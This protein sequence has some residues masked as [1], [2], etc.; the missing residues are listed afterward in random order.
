[1]KIETLKSEIVR[2]LKQIIRIQ[3]A[4]LLLLIVAYRLKE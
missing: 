3:T 1:M 4:V 2:D